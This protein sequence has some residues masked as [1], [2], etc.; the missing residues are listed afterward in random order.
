MRIGA[1]GL[2]RIVSRGL[3]ARTGVEPVIF[4]LKGRRVNHY[5]TGPHGNTRGEPGVPEF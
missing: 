3:V 1:R 2:K 4:A 5:S